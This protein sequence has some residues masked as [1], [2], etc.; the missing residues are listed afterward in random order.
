MWAISKRKEKSIVHLKDCFADS[1]FSTEL[2]WVSLVVD[3]NYSKF[4]L[5]HSDIL[6]HVMA[7]LVVKHFSSC[8][9][10]WP[11]TFPAPVEARNFYF[12]VSSSCTENCVGRKTEP[13]ARTQSVLVTCSRSVLGQVKWAF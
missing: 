9:I 3:S 5:E 2:V 8:S 6:K 4:T 1:S 7:G 12:L 11:D 10:S 13:S